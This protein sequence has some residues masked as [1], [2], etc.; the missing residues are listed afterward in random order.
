MSTQR[1]GATRAER[2]P[3]LAG[4]ETAMHRAARRAQ[5]RAQEIAGRTLG[6]KGSEQSGTTHAAVKIHNPGALSRSWGHTIV[7]RLP[8]DPMQFDVLDLLDAVG[9]LHGISIDNVDGKD[10]IL[11]IVKKPA[12]QESSATRLHGRRVEAMF[13]YVAAAIGR[14]SLV[15]REDSRPAFAE[16]PDMTIPDYRL[17]TDDGQQ[18]LVE[19]K[20]CH[21]RKLDSRIVFKAQYLSQLQTYAALVRAEL[22]LAIYW[23]TFKMWT[24]LSPQDLHFDGAVWMTTF[25]NAMMQNTMA[26]L[27]DMHVGTTPPLACRFLENPDRP[28]KIDANGRAEFTIRQVEIESAGRLVTENN[29]KNLA[30]Q[31]MLF[32]EWPASERLLVDDG[33]LLGVEHLAEPIT[34]TP[35][36]DFEFIGTLSRMASRRYDELTAPS[37]RIERLAPNIG[38]PGTL[39]P[40]IPADYVGQQLPL[41]ILVQQPFGRSENK[42]EPSG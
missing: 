2:D 30:F 40:A 3:D 22:R 20:N 9:R 6:L 29:E 5:R 38:D 14:C 15:K 28:P 25:R 7:K 21:K 42:D 24:L 19:V 17:V 26:A 18:F 37:G 1:K 32:G 35:G 33:R 10:Q 36:Q 4:V 27:G 16:H 39:T 41:W 12:L 11:D 13:G 8:H 31:L 23:S 34:R